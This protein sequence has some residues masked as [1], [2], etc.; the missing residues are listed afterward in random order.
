MEIISA[1]VA[2][3]GALIAGGALYLTYQSNQRAIK[4]NR[5]SVQPYL[6]DWLHVGFDDL[7]LDFT[8][9]NKG[10]GTC[11]VTMC[12]YSWDGHVIDLDTL[13]NKIR[14]NV[15][16]YMFIQIA[17]I[18]ATTA[19]SKDETIS[20]VKLSYKDGQAPDKK[21]C[22]QSLDRADKLITGS[23]KLHINYESL[24]GDKFD[25]LAEC[26]VQH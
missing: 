8:L 18:D 19:L 16:K 4:H 17:N 7:I 21:V 1:I 24:Y 3:V 9:T 26:K 20:I 22:N 14:K 12:H 6:S 23:L 15:D 11:K 2:V 5:L 13:E 25:H 10:L